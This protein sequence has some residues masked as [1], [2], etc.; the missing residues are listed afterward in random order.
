MNNCADLQSNY[1]WDCSGCSCPGDVEEEEWPYDGCDPSFQCCD[2]DENLV[3]DGDDLNCDDYCDSHG[4]TCEYLES[5]FGVDC[6]L[7]SGT[8]SCACECEDEEVQCPA[9]CDVV[10]YAI[11]DPSCDTCDGGVGGYCIG[12]SDNS[13]VECGCPEGTDCGSTFYGNG[14]NCGG[15]GNHYSFLT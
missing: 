6:G 10:D 3:S 2:L 8:N 11:E 9:N 14:G 13:C 5:T 7:G 12:G 4:Y 1:G 15:Y